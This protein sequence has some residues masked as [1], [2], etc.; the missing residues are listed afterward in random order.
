MDKFIING[1]EF[2]DFGPNNYTNGMHRVTAYPMPEGFI[3]DVLDG[4]YPGIFLNPSCDCRHTGNE[5]FGVWGTPEQ[6][7]GFL[8]SQQEAQIAAQVIEACGG[9]DKMIRM[10][11]DE[12]RAIRDELTANY[13]DWWV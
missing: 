10:D 5:F 4:R 2:C 6:Y 13:K 8:K 9:P 3:Q 12:F 1:V 7:K 11:L